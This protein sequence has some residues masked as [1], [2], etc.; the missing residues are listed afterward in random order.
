MNMNKS[1][2]N[3]FDMTGI[4]FNKNLNLNIIDQN[5]VSPNIN[6]KNTAYQD[7]FNSSKMSNNMFVGKLPNIQNSYDIKDNNINNMNN[8][9]NI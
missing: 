9:S 7:K 1:R 5:N 6:M 8:I 3:G 2:G 4:S